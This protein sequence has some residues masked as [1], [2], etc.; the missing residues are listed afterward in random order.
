MNFYFQRQTKPNREFSEA[1]IVQIT[2]LVH[3]FRESS[4]PMSLIMDKLVIKRPKKHLIDKILEL[5]L[6]R[7]RKE[8]RKKKSKN[9]DKCKFYFLFHIKQIIHFLLCL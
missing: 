5:G 9:A 3:E 1:E 8:L 7:D 2:Q 6:I 4:D